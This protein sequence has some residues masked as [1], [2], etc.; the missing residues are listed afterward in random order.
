MAFTDDTFLQLLRLGPVSRHQIPI[1]GGELYLMI[2]R[3]F[4]RGF[5]VYRIDAGGNPT[6]QLSGE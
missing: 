3:L 6:W 2:Q 4:G 5:K 1:S